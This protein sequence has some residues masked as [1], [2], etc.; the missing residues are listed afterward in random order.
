MRTYKDGNC[1]RISDMSAAIYNKFSIKINNVLNNTPR[2]LGKYLNI[3][4]CSKHQHKHT[5]IYI[6]DSMEDANKFDAST[7]ICES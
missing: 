7:H 5:A 1:I 2:L 6:F 4:S 3:V